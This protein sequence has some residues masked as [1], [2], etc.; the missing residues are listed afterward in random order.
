MSRLYCGTSFGDSELSSTG[1]EALA[2]L[3]VDSLIFRILWLLRLRKT[4]QVLKERYGALFAAF[5]RREKLRSRGF[6]KK[7]RKCIRPAN[8]T[9]LG[10]WTTE[11]SRVAQRSHSV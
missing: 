8:R 6:G 11:E 2:G 1:L 9:G 10:G 3:L 4:Y 7:D 5:I